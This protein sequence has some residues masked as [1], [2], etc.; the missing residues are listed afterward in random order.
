VICHE[1]D[2]SQVGIDLSGEIIVGKFIDL[3]RPTFSDLYLNAPVDKDK[4]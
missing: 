3:D 1:A 2:P 4:K